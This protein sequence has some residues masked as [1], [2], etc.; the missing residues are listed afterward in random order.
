MLNF[1]SPWPSSWNHMCNSDNLDPKTK[2]NLQGEQQE[3]KGKKNVLLPQNGINKSKKKFKKIQA[4]V[5]SRNKS[6]F[7]V[8]LTQGHQSMCVSQKPERNQIVLLTRKIRKERKR[9]ERKKEI[10]YLIL[11]P[12]KKRIQAM[13][14]SRTKSAL[15]IA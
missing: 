3:K 2:I 4:T 7:V 15:L 8:V 5:E 10:Y 1:P 14:E 6:A 12:L 11:E 13:V 9:K